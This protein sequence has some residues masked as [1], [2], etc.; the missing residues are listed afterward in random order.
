[1]KKLLS[2][3]LIILIT[4][5]GGLLA[6]AQYYINES[7]AIG[8]YAPETLNPFSP[9][10]QAQRVRD[11]NINYSQYVSDKI[12]CFDQELAI[13]DIK[14]HDDYDNI[15][16]ELL[17]KENMMDLYFT[18]LDHQHDEEHDEDHEHEHDHEVEKAADLCKPE[19]DT[20]EYVY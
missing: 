15:T 14:P 8:V 7:S 4:T 20:E 6:R 11:Y 9:I 2:I 17:Y 10:K 3:V 1:M 18:S 12:D 16:E 5:Y 19:V 13:H